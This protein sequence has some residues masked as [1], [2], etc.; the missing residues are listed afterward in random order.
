MKRPF[1]T[2]AILLAR[3]GLAAGYLGS[4]TDRFGAWGKAGTPG[5]VWGDF[6][7][8][9]ARIEANPLVPH[10]AA[11][12]VAWLV[13]VLESGLGLSLLV[14]LRARTMGCVSGCLLL[15]IAVAMAASP[16]GIHALL[17]SG[18]LSAAGASMLLATRA[19][20]I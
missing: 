14:G 4:V 17:L 15:V 5:I 11:P 1:Q 16:M 20:E 3:F 18:V 9:I 8:F 19:D 13:T 6:Q 10:G 2:M 7:H 12:I